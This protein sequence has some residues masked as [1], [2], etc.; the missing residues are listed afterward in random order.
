MR[1]PS[2]VSDQVIYF[3]AVDATDLKTRETDLATFTVYRSRNGGAAT[4]YTTPTVTEVDKTNMPGVYKL[5]L[6]EDMTIGEGNDSEEFCL[7]ITHDGMAPVTRVFELYRRTVTAGETVTASSGKV[8]VPDTQK[9]DVDTVKARAVTD[10]GEGNTVYLGTEAWATAAKLLKYLQLLARSDAAIAT[11]NATE[12][13]EINASGGS[14]VG[15]FS[16][17]TDAA[18]ALQTVLLAVSMSAAGIEAWDV[19]TICAAACAAALA[20]VNLDHLC[21]TAAS[22]PAVPA[23]TY[24]DQLMD[25]GTA[26]YDRSTDSLQAIRDRGDA[27]WLTAAGFALASVCTET[28]LARLDQAV[29]AAKT[30]TTD[31]RAAIAA[32]LLDLRAAI[33]GKTLRQA[34]RYIAATTAGKAAGAGTGTETFKGLD[35]STDRVKATVD[36]DGN[37]TAVAYDPS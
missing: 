10:V 2:G 27:A 22:I 36:E 29:S 37:R 11:D 19:P 20:A 35:G 17:Q 32:A 3:V 34:L 21:G 12:L 8:A 4:A 15:D 14:G 18:E 25:N 33:D 26:A 5:L 31:E 30:L 6:D 23:G 16:N 28:R 1:F 24:L 7:H 9:V 13:G